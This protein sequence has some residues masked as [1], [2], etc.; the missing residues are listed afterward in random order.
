MQRLA[1]AAVRG[2]ATAVGV[3]LC[4]LPAHAGDNDIVLSR[5]GTINGGAAVGNGAEFRSLTS[6]LGVVL[7]PRLLSPADTLGF[8]GFQFAADVGFTSID[9][10]A[11]YWRVRAGSSQPAGAG[12]HGGGIVPTVGVFARKGIWLPVPSFEFGAGVVQLV[13]SRMMAAQAYG[14]LALH[15]GYHDLPLP[16]LAVRGAVSRMMGE[17]DLDLTVVSVDASAGKEIGV[18]GTFNLT[19]YAGYNLLLVIPRSELID[20]TPQIAGD[21]ALSFVFADQDN[22]LRHRIFA[23]TRLRYSIFALTLEGQF[24]LAGG[25]VDDQPGTTSDCAAVGTTTSFCDSRDL[26]SGQLTV[27][28][29]LGV[30]F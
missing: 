28:T 14:K 10:D 24:T 29:S 1:L 2:L 6:E 13:G 3:L 4:A 8:G 11:S 26:A 21:A 7:A 23:G 20:K 16:S 30:D 27:V 19:P 22:I 9:S 15:E 5:L 17:S 12:P 25:S 18:G